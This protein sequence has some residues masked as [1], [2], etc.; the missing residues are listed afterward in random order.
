MK[1]VL[2][3]PVIIE[4]LICKQY[5]FTGLHAVKLFIPSMD[6]ISFGIL[7]STIAVSSTAMLAVNGLGL[8]AVV[9]VHPIMG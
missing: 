8:L 6:I 2:N 9:T 5:H 4:S 1:C 7:L 3:V